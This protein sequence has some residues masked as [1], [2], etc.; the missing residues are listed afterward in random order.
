[1]SVATAPLVGLRARPTPLLRG[2]VAL[3]AAIIVGCAPADAPR[4]AAVQQRVLA[5]MECYECV[6]GELDSVVAQGVQA[7]PLLRTALLEGPAPGRLARMDSSLRY[8]TTPRASNTVIALQLGNYRALYRMRST[9]AL[10]AIGGTASSEALCA[11]R[12]VP[13]LT[14]GDRLALDSAIQRVGGAC[15]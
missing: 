5:L 1:M 2:A 10:T 15:P 11:G 14:P 9:R 12:S 13:Q 4:A 7:V 8:Y 3:C 6:D